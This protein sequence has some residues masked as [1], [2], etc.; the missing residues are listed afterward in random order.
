MRSAVSHLY[1]TTGSISSFPAEIQT[2]YLSNTKNFSLYFTEKNKFIKNPSV[3]DEKNGDKTT[4]E[5]ET[6]VKGEVRNEEEE[7]NAAQEKVSRED[8]PT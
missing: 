6:D 7:E 3:A 1:K 4:V 8:G 5:N 2:I